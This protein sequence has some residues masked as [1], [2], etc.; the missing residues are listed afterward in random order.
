MRFGFVRIGLANIQ[1]LH[2]LG[3]YVKRKNCSFCARNGSIARSFGRQIAASGCFGH[4]PLTGS[5]RPLEGKAIV[6]ATFVDKLR[7][8]GREKSKEAFARR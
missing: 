7:F 1:M 8:F 5:D 3:R 6:P 4:Q 2:F